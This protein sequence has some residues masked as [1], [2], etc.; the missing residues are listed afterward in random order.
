MRS[1][2]QSSGARR[3]HRVLPCLASL[4]VLTF[5]CLPQA[6]HAQYDGGFSWVYDS[7]SDSYEAVG[8]YQYNSRTGAI[9]VVRS[10]TGSY[11]VIFE[12]L[13]NEGFNGGNVQVSAY[14]NSYS[15]CTVVSWGDNAASVNCY[16]AD[17][18]PID[19]T[20]NVWYLKPASDMPDIAFAWANDQSSASY[21]PNGLYSYNSEGGTVTA[22]RSGVGQYAMA[23]ADFGNAAGNGGSVYVTAYGSN[24]RCQAVSWGVTSVAIECYDP[25]GAPVDTR[26]TVLWMKPDPSASNFAYAWADNSSSASYTPQS[27]WLFNGAGGAVT[28]TRSG[29][30][31]YQM[32]FADYGTIGY[33]LGHV[34]VT[35][36]DG[37]NSC[38]VRGWAG[39]TVAIDCYDSSGNPADS[40]Y[41]VVFLKPEFP[42][43][44]GEEVSG[45]NFVWGNN[46]SAD[47]YTPDLT[48]LHNSNGLNALAERLG[49]G[50]YRTDFESLTPLLGGGHV[51]ISGYGG[52]SEYCNSGGWGTSDVVVNCWDN[53]GASS[54]LQYSALYL[55]PETELPGI[56]Y[57]WAN[58]ASTASYQPD[59][60]YTYNAGGGTVTAE[61]TALGKY[62]VLF[63]GM[64]NVGLNGGAVLATA[65]GSAARCSVESWGTNRAWVNCY[66]AAGNDFDTRFDL[67]F[68]KPEEDTPVMAF[69]W[70][71][72]PSEASYTPNPFY[73][74]NSGGGPITVTRSATGVYNV[75]F[76]GF[77]AEGETGGNVQVSSYGG[78]TD[79]C[80]LMS[81]GGESVNVTCVDQTGSPVDTW[82]TVLYMRPSMNSGTSVETEILTTDQ[83][84][85]N[86]PNPFRGQTTLRYTLPVAS[87]VEILVHD[88][89]GRVVRQYEFETKAAGR[90]EIAVDAEDLSSGVYF[91]RLSSEA[92]VSLGKMTI[93]R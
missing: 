88:L 60:S 93:S 69:A 89:T 62:N 92:G 13:E 28:A 26:Y 54:D 23:F 68:L 47:S 63:E 49:T 86:Y 11:N 1:R 46:A 51:Q 4:L 75:D 72:Q 40:R 25:A 33:N 32:T 76:D 52:T 80:R 17:G 64:E 24:A 14:G 53:S 65:Y 8:L 45:L 61:R 41:Q 39:D 6:A 36:Y 16:D 85:S 9:N 78:G 58:D 84:I 81:W 7:T 15:Y 22:T 12:D 27:T 42:H 70:A 31:V 57:T 48:Y 38:V 56:A 66:D 79:Y 2:Y 87:P 55:T 67:L 10:G 18:N 5:I 35:S 82:F 21:T 20:F 77:A 91:Y 59:A 50:T 3:R 30:G 19:S 44:P 71:N 43:P 73:S 74:Y 29:V 90:H 37:P 34:Q 83:L